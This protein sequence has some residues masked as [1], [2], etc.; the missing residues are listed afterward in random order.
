MAIENTGGNHICIYKCKRNLFM[1]QIVVNCICNPY[2]CGPKMDDVTIKTLCVCIHT[3]Y[4]SYII[5]IIFID[6]VYKK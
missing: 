4:N 6:T 3:K 5:H 2:Y 1:S